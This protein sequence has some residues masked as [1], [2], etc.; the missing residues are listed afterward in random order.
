MRGDDRGAVTAELAVLLPV[1]ALLVG[2]LLALTAGAATHLRC[3]D[4]ARAG[5]RAAA[6]GD[7]DVA[8]AVVVR[9]VA[10]DGARTAVARSDGWVVVTVEQTVGPTVPL[11]GGVTV[12]AHAT[13]RAEP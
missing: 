8:V 12:R 13:S 10:G 7:D 11:L 3:G 9:R 4:A 5:A 2:V 1:V 6:L